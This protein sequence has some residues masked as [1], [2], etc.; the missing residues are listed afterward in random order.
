MLTRLEVD[1]FKNLLGLAV[2]WGPHTCIA[3]PNGVGKSNVFDAIRF[4]S[5]LADH[6]ILEAALKARGGDAETADLRDLFWTDGREMSDRF[7]IAAE[8]V[9]E[10]QAVDDFGRTAEASSTYLRYEIEVGYEPPTER[11]TLGRLSLRREELDFFSIGEGIERW[12]FPH[13]RE[14]RQAALRNSRRAHAGYISTESADSDPSQILVHQDGQAGLPQ[15]F[16]SDTTPR[17]AIASAN[18]V[19]HPTVLAARR[20]M[21]SWRILS[22]E[23]SV[24]RA[25]DR[26]HSE[27]VLGSRG[28]HLPAVL[29]RLALEA[30]ERGEDE[31]SLHARIASRLAGLVGIQE[32][33]VD[34]DEV[35]Q[36]LTLVAREGEASLPARSL[37]DGTLRFLAL[38]LVAEDP[39]AK[40]LFCLEE[41][42]NGIHPAK[43]SAMVELIRELAID[44]EERPGEDNPLRQIIVA[45]HSPYFV[46]LQDPQDL[47]LAVPAAVRTRSGQPAQT[48]RCLPLHGTWRARDG[49]KGIGM[50]AL[51][52]YLAVPPGAP[53]GMGSWRVAEPVR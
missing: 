43:L 35:R 18:T 47:L 38:C 17:T 46:Q 34:V 20:E 51:L 7:S 6:S 37:S 15:R 12:H 41:P 49:E 8:M 39:S 23:P 1:G 42:E 30:K 13:S 32:I 48:L 22:F 11:G 36:L 5:L 52:D 29:H 53:L 26:F 21:Q 10:P 33:G 40:G 16:S 2:E 50:A 9:V 45:T 4:L 19:A 25:A 3:G 44:S 14:F 28:Q 24:M 27:P 31:A